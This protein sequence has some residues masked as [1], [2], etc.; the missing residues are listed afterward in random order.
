MLTRVQNTCQVPCQDKECYRLKGDTIFSTTYCSDAM[1][2]VTAAAHTGVLSMR[3][4]FRA[5][6]RLEMG[7]KQGKVKLI[8]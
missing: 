4:R 6:G 7:G 3:G 8:R 2:S 5:F 1:S